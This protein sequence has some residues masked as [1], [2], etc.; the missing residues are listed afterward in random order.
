MKTRLLIVLIVVFFSL[1]VF[2]LADAEETDNQSL[3]QTLQEQIKS[4]QAKIQDLQ[5]ELE[6]LV[7]QTKELEAAVQFSQTLTTGVQN[8]EVKQLQELL[9][10]DPEIY[11]EGRITGFFGSATQQ[12]V[13][14]FQEKYKIEAIGIVGPKTRAKLN[15]LYGGQ[16]P[17]MPAIPAIPAV[18]GETSAIPAIPATPATTTIP[19]SVPSQPFITI[20]SPNGGEQWVRDNTYDITWKSWGL[21]KVN[22]E[23]AT[24]AAAWRIAFD[25][26]SSQGRYS[27]TIP[28]NQP[29]ST[30]YKVF[31]WDA[32]GSIID[33]QDYSD[34]Y[35]SIAAT[36]TSPTT[37]IIATTTAATTTT[38]TI[39]PTA[40]TTPTTATTS[41]QTQIQT[42]TQTQTTIQTISTTTTGAATT[43]NISFTVISPNGGE[44]LAKGNTY[45]IIWTATGAV[46]T[47]RISLYEAGNFKE[48]LVA[49]AA[50]T[51]SWNWAVS[52]AIATG[53]QYKIRVFNLTYPNNFDDSNNY[54]S[55]IASSTT[56]AATTTSTFTVISPNGGESWTA[57]NTYLVTWTTTGTTISTARIVY[58]SSNGTEIYVGDTSNTGSYNLTVHP[59]TPV[60][61]NYKLKIFN[62]VYPYESDESNSYF[63]IIASTTA[64]TSV[65]DTTPPSIPT[66]LVATPFS[67]SQINLSWTASTDNVG[68]AGY[69]IY[70][71][72]YISASPL[73]GTSS[74]TSYSETGLYP[75]ILYT[76]AV[77][78]YD[79]AGNES[80]RSAS[81]SA[82]P[83]Q[84]IITI[85]SPNGGEQWMIGN[86]YR[87]SWT[88]DA[89]SGRM[90]IHGDAAGS[91]FS[92]CDV[93]YTGNKY[94]DWTI[95]TNLTPGTQYKIEIHDADWGPTDWSN[96]Y[97]SIVASAPA[98]SITV[99]SPNGGESWMFAQPG[100]SDIIWHNITW[101]SAGI[102]NVHIDV[103]KY[104]SPS[105]AWTL[106][107]NIP[108]SPGS[109]PW[110][111]NHGWPTLSAGDTYKIRVFTYPLPPSGGWKINEN[112]DESDGYFN[113][114]S[115]ATTSTTT[116]SASFNDQLA[117]IAAAI[118]QLVEEINL[119]FAHR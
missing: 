60:S 54:F 10:K 16:I 47:A 19:V 58:L 117:A 43:T 38:L 92:V 13:K 23:L 113:I 17:A 103:T 84:P 101:Q 25:V 62:P 78:A 35:F 3:V 79:A 64:T 51:G 71:P 80:S 48:I 108:A 61:S 55:I 32:E 65:T 107:S 29:T 45:P 27:W 52:S 95:P 1:G 97:F 34:N 50:N 70:H 109:F 115:S 73:I 72:D 40:T 46:S 14:R 31:V 8:E 44:Q 86:T 53:N 77:S 91:H 28:A 56:A 93:V 96:N 94:C 99:T 106:I 4:L 7:S 89:E 112:Y 26:P 21:G 18:P 111:I 105:Q 24:S 116:S 49:E 98:A 15:E 69:H 36:A 41:T 37:T 42:Q 75:S 76:Y 39:T 6:N 119:F 22:I 20:T 11:P 33:A 100:T 9:A 30:S 82:R 102:E 68:V 59:T 66:N 85:T 114:I 118:S 90:F 87:V 88:S 67:T 63:S 57:G 12:A 5:K 74:T 83:K 81:V 110:Q 2:S 104:G